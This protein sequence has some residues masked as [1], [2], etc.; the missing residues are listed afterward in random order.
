MGSRNGQKTALE[1]DKMYLKITKNRLNS[2]KKARF[3]KK[4]SVFLFIMSDRLL[5]Y[6]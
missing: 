3:M 4:F 1:G 6:I 5:K 2:L